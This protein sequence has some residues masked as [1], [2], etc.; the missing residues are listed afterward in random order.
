MESLR[1]LKKS[2]V[3]TVNSSILAMSWDGGNPY[4]R[5]WISNDAVVMKWTYWK[6]I[7]SAKC[8][9]IVRSSWEKYEDKI[10]GFLMFDPRPTPENIINY[11]DQGLAY[12]SS[13]P[14]AIDLALQMGCKRIYL[15]GVDHYT[16]GSKSH[17]WQCWGHKKQPRGP[18][19]P[20]TQQKQSFEH[21]M[22]AY[23]ALNG[24]A[25]FMDAKIY[26][27]NENSKVEI[28]EKIN[29]QDSLL[30]R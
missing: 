24:F 28:F 17:F 26:N 21:N 14:S 16:D 2:V 3:I 6:Q 7:K 1:P 15:L 13:V 19:A 20:I 27:C 10:N 29:F 23:E 22:Q 4:N 9:K 12:C 5:Y 30:R 8:T 25:D 11:S 18:L